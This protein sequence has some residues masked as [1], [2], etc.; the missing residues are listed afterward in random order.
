[1][2]LSAKTEYACLALLEMAQQHG[3]GEPVQIRR[4]AAEQGIPSRFLVQILLRLKG[5]G[6]VS[7]TRG[8]AGGYRL[9]HSP[10]EITL[11]DIIEVMEGEA[12]PE[13]SAGKRTPQVVALLGL[14]AELGA[15]QRDRLEDISLADLAERAARNEPMWYI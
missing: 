4:I 6:L 2:K 9:A 11:A 3:S 13:S 8:A 7:S 5:A 1:M 15:S 10:R 14:C 12:R